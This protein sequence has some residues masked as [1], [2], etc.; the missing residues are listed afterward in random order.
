M[1]THDTLVIGAGPA[2]LALAAALQQRGLSFLLL[3]KSDRVGDT[4]HNHYDRLHLH[5]VKE[6][7]HLP[8]LPFPDHYPRYVS[9]RQLL[10]YLE[11]YARH[12]DIRPRF[13]AEVEEIRRADEGF[14]V[15]LTGGEQL[16]ARQVVVTTGLNRYPFRPHLPDEEDFTGQLLHSADY[17]NPDAFAGQRVAVVGMGN[18]GAEIALDLSEAGLPTFLS[19]RGPVNII[20]REVLGRP[21]QVSAVQMARLPNW[22]GDRIGL[23]LRRFTVGDLEQYG[24]ELSA[25]A[26]ARQLREKGKAPVID[27]GTA[28]AIR[29]G[30]IRVIPGIDH[31][32]PTG[33]VTRD[34][35]ELEIDAV[36]FATGYRAELEELIPGIDEQLDGRGCPVSPAATAPWDGLYFL[37]FDNYTP[38]GTLGVIR[39]DTDRVAAAIA[40]RQQAE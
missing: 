13:R 4:W 25:E 2:G 27:I 32:T 1:K 3:E 17:R 31:F 23:I 37:G 24:L 28:D 18:S 7:S 40:R 33:I 6:Y 5:T 26:P 39:R 29:R 8:G 35:E 30:D 15:Q 11:E 12:F 19:V 38:G 9:R 36:I 14:V 34:G 20:P 21:V 16:R 10:D 22:L